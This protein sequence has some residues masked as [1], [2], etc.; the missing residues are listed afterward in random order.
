M[1]A[2]LK[3]WFRIRVPVSLVQ[4]LPESRRRSHIR[5]CLRTGRFERL[6]RIAARNDPYPQTAL[7]AAVDGLMT[8]GRDDLI[9]G[10]EP[11]AATHAGFSRAVWEA[12][13]AHAAG[14]PDE[15]WR[16]LRQLGAD[17]R[18]GPFQRMCARAWSAFLA[19][20][21]L[22]PGDGAAGPA[23]FQFWDTADPPADLAGPMTSWQRLGPGYRRYD[24]AAARA[25]LAAEF[26][27]AAVKTFDM[28]PH[29]AVQSD[30]FRL[31]R[32]TRDGGLC[33]DADEQPRHGFARHWP[34]MADRTVV[35]FYSNRAEGHFTNGLLACPPGS[36]LAQACLDEAG[37]R[38][39][40]DPMGH[41]YALAG[42]G[43]LT[44]MI[45]AVAD[46]HGL[47]GF[48]AVPRG[49][50]RRNLSRQVPAAYKRDARSWHLWQRDKPWEQSTTGTR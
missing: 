46:R 17:Y 39:R 28:C 37:R 50:V 43:M 35:W 4:R 15:A 10:L 23:I 36:A 47:D 19:M 26:G 20:P 32:L 42:P 14:E 6:A 41:V 16:R 18:E 33:A 21:R 8:M 49:Y 27:Q 31:A 2:H 12:V 45:L 30:Y 5:A 44:D 11:A 25:Y 29:P 1:T 22:A 3:D 38:I 24:A 40:S 13:R 48:L 9:P 34:A 7:Y